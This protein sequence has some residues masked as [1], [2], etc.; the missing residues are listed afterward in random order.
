[1][2]P[3][4][5]QRGYNAPQPPE[6]YCLSDVA[7]ASIPEEVRKMFHTDEAGRVLFFTS[8][9]AETGGAVPFSMNELAPKSGKSED[10]QSDEVKKEEIMKL[11]HSVRYLA[12]KQKRDELIAAKRKRE[13]DEVAARAGEVK[14]LKLAEQGKMQDRLDEVTGRAIDILSEQ[15]A[16]ETRKTMTETAGADGNAAGKDVRREVELLEA[17]WR[18]EAQKQ[19]S[20]LER[21][22]ERDI[23][24]ARRVELTG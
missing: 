13:A 16:V 6:V 23:K 3:S 11:G 12:A 21:E 8:P 14:K 18:V 5:G 24:Q 9:P 10:K 15:I 1:M 17:R 7:N 4:Q 19:R 20:K 2:G 22:V